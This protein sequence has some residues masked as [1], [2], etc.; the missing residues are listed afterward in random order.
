MKMMLGK[1][2]NFWKF[3]QVK[4]VEICTSCPTLRWRANFSH[5]SLL[6]DNS[7]HFLDTLANEK[8]SNIQFFEDLEDNKFGEFFHF[9]ILVLN[10]WKKKKWNVFFC[11][12]TLFSDFL[13]EVNS[14]GINLD[15]TNTG[16]INAGINYAKNLVN[17]KRPPSCLVT[18]Q[19][20]QKTHTG[21]N[22]P[23]LQ[24]QQDSQE[25]LYKMPFVLTC[26]MDISTLK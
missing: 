18:T 7:F 6:F 24:M 21:C 12:N 15:E 2:Y 23:I 10:F 19:Y 1:M 8:I 11:G 16:Q 5:N 3:F 13:I 14:K 4:T 26:T 22:Q 17:Q 20:W 9:F 25:T